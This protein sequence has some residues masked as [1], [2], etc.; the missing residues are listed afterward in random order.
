MGPAIVARLASFSMN[1]I[2]QAFAGHLGDN[3][4]AAFSIVNNVI[5]GFSFVLEIKWT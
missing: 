2:T 1:V 3:E 5:L 4:L